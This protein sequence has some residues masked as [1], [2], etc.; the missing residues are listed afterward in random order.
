[1][2]TCCHVLIDFDVEALKVLCFIMFTENQTKKKEKEEKL[3]EYLNLMT[4]KGF[5][6]DKQPQGIHNIF[7]VHKQT[8]LMGIFD[9]QWTC[10]HTAIHQY[11]ISVIFSSPSCSSQNFVFAYE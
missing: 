7:Y 8:N 5:H 1:M 10:L 11:V 3:F 6:D 4:M 9:T 2:R